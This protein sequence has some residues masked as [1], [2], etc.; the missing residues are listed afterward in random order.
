MSVFTW[1]T[2]YFPLTADP[3]LVSKDPER[4]AAE[5]LG[6]E[7]YEKLTRPLDDRLS[8]GAGVSVRIATRADRVDPG[9]AEHVVV[10]PVLGARSHEQ[11]AVRTR[12]LD[13]MRGWKDAVVLLPVP[14][15]PAWRAQEPLPVKPLLT[16]LYGGRRQTL[17]EICRQTD[18]FDRREVFALLDRGAGPAPWYLLN[19]ALWWKEFIANVPRSASLAA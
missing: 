18:F 10:V 19:V 7:L 17:D 9:E 11:A 12:A 4:L 1:H 14:T 6:L 2:T 3:K 8:W 16:D 13:A 15:S 5:K